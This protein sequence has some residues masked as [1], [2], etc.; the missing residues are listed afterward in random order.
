MARIRCPAGGGLGHLVLSGTLFLP[1]WRGV[2]AEPSYESGWGLTRSGSQSLPAS[3]L[4][5]CLSGL[6][7]SWVG[8][9]EMTWRDSVGEAGSSAVKPARGPSGWEGGGAAWPGQVDVGTRTGQLTAGP[10]C[11]ALQALAEHEDELPEHFKPSQLIKDLAKEIRLSEVGLSRGA[12]SP[13]RGTLCLP[14]LALPTAVCQGQPC[15]RRLLPQPSEAG[16]PA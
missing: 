13:G 10:A 14:G 12:A 3:A 5:P 15:L 1:L 7:G 2:V 6:P 16:S 4:P 11:A 9:Q 8:R